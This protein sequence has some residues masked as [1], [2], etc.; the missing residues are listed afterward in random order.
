MLK[1]LISYPY[2]F[3]G[4]VDIV[5]TIL[6]KYEIIFHLRKTNATDLEYEEFLKNISVEFHSKVVLH[7]A[8]S[9]QKNFNIKG[10]HFSTKNRFIEN[11]YN[12]VG[13]RSTS[14]H[15]ISEVAELSDIY[16]YMFLSPIFPSISKLGYSGDLHLLTVEE[17]LK[18]GTLTKV[19]ALGGI[20]HT[21]LPKIVSMG[22]D[23][24]AVLGAVWTEEVV[25][26]IKPID[27]LLLNKIFSNR[28]TMKKKIADIQY[29]TQ[30]CGKYTHAQQA[31]LMFE[32]GVKWVQIRMKNSTPKEIIEQSKEAL[33]YANECGGIL[34]I[35][36]S[37]EIAKQI[38]AHGVH[39][40]M[41]DI[42]IDE[43]R[44]YLGDE[45]I[46][47]GTANTLDDIKLQMSRGADY[48]GL[49]PYKF[50]TTKKNLSPVIGLE[51]YKSLCDEMKRC[52][53][54]IPIVA[55]GS[56]TLEDVE[57]IK[58]TGLYGAAISSALLEPWL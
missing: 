26:G 50:T 47:G 34:L 17:F 39:L 21:L 12:C 32:N 38:G 22:F 54:S 41:N 13:T 35:N 28:M 40:G 23:G 36:D 11:T 3:D 25:S 2:F 53:I 10:V 6:S 1:I 58:S 31:K 24:F 18:E 46:I 4:E 52:N 30:D 43:A 9:L 20:D 14:C 49:G 45:F 19:V 5:N 44:E 37:I 33:Q 48:L 15:S 51:G 56:V 42:S 55:V 8:Y 57:D 29:I 16:D 7:G 27:Y